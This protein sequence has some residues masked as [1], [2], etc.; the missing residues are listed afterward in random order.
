[1]ITWKKQMCDGCRL[2]GL[3]LDDAIGWFRLKEESEVAAN[4]R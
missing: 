3:G 4:E 2:V 1:M